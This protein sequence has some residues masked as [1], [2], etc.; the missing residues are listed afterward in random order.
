MQ[1]VMSRQFVTLV[2]WPSPHLIPLIYQYRVPGAIGSSILRVERQFKPSAAIFLDPSEQSAPRPSPEPSTPEEMLL[3]QDDGQSQLFRLPF[4]RRKD[5]RAHLPAVNVGKPPENDSST[6]PDHTWSTL[7]T[8]MGLFQS[9]PTA[10]DS[11]YILDTNTRGS[12]LTNQNDT[13]AYDTQGDLHQHDGFVADNMQVSTG[14]MIP[15]GSVSITPG[16][17]AT[18]SE[19]R[20]ESLF[21]PDTNWMFLDSLSQAWPPIAS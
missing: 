2:L 14:N 4:H 3:K 11:N 8:T 7:P 20:A 17:L 15:N 6:S 18:D 13:V 10:N 1:D 16:M 5:A 21:F 12:I 19:S 9:N